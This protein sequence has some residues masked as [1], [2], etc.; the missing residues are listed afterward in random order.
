MT[1][2]RR[3]VP[4]ITGDEEIGGSIYRNLKKLPSAASASST[5]A[6]TV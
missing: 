4:K 5:L 1:E 6:F 2:P 3:E